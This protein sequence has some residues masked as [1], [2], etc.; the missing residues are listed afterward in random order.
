MEHVEEA[1]PPPA[2]RHASPEPKKESSKLAFPPRDRVRIWHDRTGQFRTDAAFL[3]LR[4]GMLRLHKTNGVIVEVP[5]EKISIKD[6][7]YVEKVTSK[8][9]EMATATAN[10]YVLTNSSV[11]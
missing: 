3:G 6:L 5:E 10:D 2:P 4:N 8:Q 1:P 9:S 7:D 11:S